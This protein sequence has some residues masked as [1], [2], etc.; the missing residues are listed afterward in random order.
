MTI[1]IKP[2]AP[3]KE[4]KKKLEKPKKE[5]VEPIEITVSESKQRSMINNADKVVIQTDDKQLK[6]LLEKMVITHAINTEMLKRITDALT[7]PEPKVEIKEVIVYKDAPQ[8][9]INAVG[10]WVKIRK[11]RKGFAEKENSTEKDAIAICEKWLGET[12][13]GKK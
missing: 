10:S 3:V 9:V 8:S 12:K 2:T 6:E 1:I 11:A 13:N 7:N 5:I 4:E